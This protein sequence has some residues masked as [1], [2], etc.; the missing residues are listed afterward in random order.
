MV[1]QRSRRRPAS[2]PTRSRRKSYWRPAIK[3]PRCCRHWQRAPW[4][5]LRW[6][7]GEGADMDR[8]DVVLGIDNYASFPYNLVQYLG[9][10]GEQVIVRRNNEITLADITELA[11]VA[12]VLSPGPGK[13]GRASCR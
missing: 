2:L 4:I 5:L 11:P 1:W 12:A 13:I 3:P 10:L 9:E 6:T 7:V 8:K